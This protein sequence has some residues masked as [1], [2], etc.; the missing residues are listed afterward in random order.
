MSLRLTQMFATAD[1]NIEMFSKIAIFLQNQF[2]KKMICDLISQ[3]IFKPSST[4]QKL[5]QGDFDSVQLILAF[6]LKKLS[7]N[8]CGVTFYPSQKW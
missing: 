1:H 2:I 4:N 6:V 7:F 8:T 3:L 5:F